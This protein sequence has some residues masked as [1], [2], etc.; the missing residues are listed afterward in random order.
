MRD[1]PKNKPPT[2]SGTSPIPTS[3]DPGAAARSLALLDAIY[4]DLA[5]EEIERDGPIDA[6]AHRLVAHAHKMVD[7]LPGRLLES[8]RKRQQAEPGRRPVTVLQSRPWTS[9]RSTPRGSSRWTGR[10]SRGWSQT[11]SAT[12]A[13]P[14][15]QYS[16]T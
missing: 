6:R 15:A 13:E 10:S 14:S 7:E 8:A 16:P 9:R 1:E 5:D 12:V 3:D 11:S 4:D 2:A